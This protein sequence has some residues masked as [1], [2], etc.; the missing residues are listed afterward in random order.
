MA[1]IDVLK[2][3]L[4][5]YLVG[6]LNLLASDRSI[7]IFDENYLN[8]KNR[9]VLS[10]SFK[11]KFGKIITSQPIIQTKIP[12][13][14]SNLLPEGH[15]RTYL[16]NLAGVKDKREFFLLK[17]LGEDLSGAVIAKPI[18]NNPYL[19]ETLI[20]EQKAE[21]NQ[22]IL[23]FSLAGVQLK[24]SALLEAS[25]GLTIPAHGVGGSW[26]VKLPSA[27]FENVP[28]N[29]FSMMMLAKKIGIDIPEIKLIDIKSISNLPEGIGSIKGKALAVKRFDR[30][31]N[32]RV[33][34]ED[35]AQIFGLFPEEKYGKGSYKNIAEVI[36]AEIG[37]DGITEFVKRLVFNALIGNAD[38]HM[39][40]WSLIYKDGRTANL[41]P[42]Y[43][44]VSTIAYIPDNNMSLNLVKS[45]RFDEL[46][47][48]AFK[49]FAGKAKLPEKMVIKTVTE[50][51][52]AF[53]DLWKEAIKD[54]PLAKSTIETIE[55]HMQ[56]LPIANHRN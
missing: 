13:F 30:D 34:I 43:D 39:K 32:Q 52:E 47:L 3:Y 29:E 12:P 22:N 14:F 45:K 5:D 44:L 31:D 27:S 56:T 41:A 21:E 55:K 6:T 37:E 36:W 53:N 19:D 7:F 9:P 23:K 50:T 46:T 33:H 10:L 40:N 48:D 15:L 35:F 24:F 4:N 17:A 51:V 1:E 11:D 16:A 26:I 25:G 18:E 38:M 2:I 8:D 20:N 49:H 54:L 42:A 28:E